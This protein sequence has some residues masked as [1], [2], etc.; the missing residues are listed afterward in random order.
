MKVPLVGA[1]TGAMSLRAPVI[2][3]VFNIRAS[4]DDEAEALIERFIKDTGAKKF[5]VFHQDDGFGQA[6]LSGTDKA[7]KKRGMEIMVKS[8]FQRNTVAVKA[9]LA[10]LLA[11]SPDVVIMVGPYT[12]IATFIKEA[13]AAGLNPSLSPF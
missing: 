1:F 5:A 10:A 2:R 13:R 7:L 12:P 11:A 6:V 8:S 4:Y 9:G 3:E